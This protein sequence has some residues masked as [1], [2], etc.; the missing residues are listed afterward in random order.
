MCSVRRS[1]ATGEAVECY[2]VCIALD[3]TQLAAY[4]NRAQA[5]LRLQQW[6]DAITDCNSAL[7]ILQQQEAA[8]GLMVHPCCLLRRPGHD[9]LRL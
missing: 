9:V 1:G 4:T 3:P 6:D 2:T 5:Y 8:G 7:A